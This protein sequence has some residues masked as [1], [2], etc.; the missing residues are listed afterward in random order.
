[1]DMSLLVQLAP[2]AIT[3]VVMV[4]RTL[5]KSLPGKYIPHILAVSGIVTG[6]LSGDGS[7]GAV[8]LQDALQGLFTSL[9]AV[10]VAETVKAPNR[11]K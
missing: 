5:V 6:L 3:M 1:M 4:V 9:A 10:G 11:D 2:V 7:T 8:M